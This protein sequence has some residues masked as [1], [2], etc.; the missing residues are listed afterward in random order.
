MA[1]KE[2]D[3][4]RLDEASAFVGKVVHVDDDG[5]TVEWQPTTTTELPEDLH[6]VA[7]YIATFVP[8]AWI[9]D[10][11]VSV[12]PEGPTEWDATEF[13]LA[14]D[15]AWLARTLREGDHDDILRTD[16]NAPEWV[17]QW[18]GPFDTYLR[19]DES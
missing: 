14:Q 13:V 5:V 8:Q 17:Q 3:L 1:F 10:Y 7:R 4:V 11:A 2:G 19:V 6:P 9:R 18:S 15:E 16:D 12:D